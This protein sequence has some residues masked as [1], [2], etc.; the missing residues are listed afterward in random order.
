MRQLRSTLA[1]NASSQS[2]L[3]AMSGAELLHYAEEFAGT[4]FEAVGRGVM[5]YV[6]PGFMPELGN[7]APAHGED[8]WVAAFSFQRGKPHQ[9]AAV[10]GAGDA[11]DPVREG[12]CL[13]NRKDE[14]GASA[15]DCHWEKDGR[16]AIVP[17]KALSGSRR[18]CM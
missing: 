12:G 14:A 10:G 9:H 17:P 6:S 5:T 15:W 3:A 18:C 8:V 1:T 11:G 2:V 4:V 13:L 16:A 7:R